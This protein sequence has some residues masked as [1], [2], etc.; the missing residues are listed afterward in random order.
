MT[1]WT[2]D[3]PDPA[4]QAG[5]QEIIDDYSDARFERKPHGVIFLDGREVAHT[6]QCPHCGGHFVSY[7]GSGQ[8]RSF[9]VRCHA[10]TC[11]QA[12]CVKVCTPWVRDCGETLFA[13]EV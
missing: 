7:R 8:R 13:R 2:P 12:A 6:L 10:V 3:Q 9:C 4:L 5:A 11:G 1:L